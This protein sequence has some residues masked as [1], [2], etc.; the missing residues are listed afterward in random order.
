MSNRMTSRTTHSGT[1]MRSL[2][3]TGTCIFVILAASG[4]YAPVGDDAT[5]D[6]NLGNSGEIDRDHGDPG[7]PSQL[8]VRPIDDEPDLVQPTPVQP[9]PTPQTPRPTMEPSECPALASLPQIAV[10]EGPFTL[11]ESV[12]DCPD[13]EGHQCHQVDGSLGFCHSV[14]ADV[15]CDGEGDVN[16]QTQPAL[17]DW[18]PG[19]CVP[20][21]WRDYLC[22]TA[23]EDYDCTPTL[24][25]ADCSV[26]DLQ[27]F[28]SNLSP[29]DGCEAEVR[30]GDSTLLLECDGENDG[31]FTSLCGCQIDG[32]YVP[33]GDLFDGEGETACLGAARDCGASGI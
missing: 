28:G 16:L 1:V 7:E 6:P 25:G 9:T 24:D 11:C 8:D 18:G 14:D 21:A 33:I 4:C 17:P 19:I 30:C 32:V 31:T 3:S 23:P 22:C 13:P 5:S 26:I 29:T 12:A 15:F 2:L 20:E 27:V 10:N